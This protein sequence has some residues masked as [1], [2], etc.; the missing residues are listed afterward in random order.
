MK[1][2]FVFA[3]VWAVLSAV[4]VEHGDEGVGG[5]LGA[6]V[7]GGR[8]GLACCWKREYHLPE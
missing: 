5:V 6:G 4:D 3:F 8:A 7:G 2:D 1:Q